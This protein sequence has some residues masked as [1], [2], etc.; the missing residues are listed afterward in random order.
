MS[1]FLQTYLAMVVTWNDFLLYVYN[2]TLLISRFL[3]YFLFK[4]PQYSI[5]YGSSLVSA[6]EL[7]CKHSFSFL[8]HDS[9]SIVRWAFL[10]HI[11]HHL[12]FV[13]VGKRPSTVS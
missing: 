11:L 6:S 9:V 8:G 4:M 1:A 2:S 12:N 10:G 7:T 5:N 3:L 13:S